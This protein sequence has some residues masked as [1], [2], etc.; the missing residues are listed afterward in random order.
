MGQRRKTGDQ[1]RL[2]AI[3]RRAV[4]GAAGVPLVA[5]VQALPAPVAQSIPAQCADWLA[6]D[7][8]MD[9]VSK[10]WA[11][12]EDLAARDHNLFR[13]TSAQVRA[14]PMYAEMD[15]LDKE[16]R[17]LGNVRDEALGELRKL[18]PRTIQDATALLAIAY[19]IHFF[20]RGDA[21]PFVRAMWGYLSKG[22]CPGC[23]QAYTAPETLR[24]F[25][26]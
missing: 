8:E 18:G 22:C 19:R 25:A 12:L 14:L 23:G 1:S 17:R 3:S 21:W 5:P 7:F 2:P 16:C 15:Q 11:D 24:G 26:Q 9:R 10:R 6:V 20:E 4:I 13:L